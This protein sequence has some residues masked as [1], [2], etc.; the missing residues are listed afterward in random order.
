VKEFGLLARHLSWDCSSCRRWQCKNELLT[1]SI[2]HMDSWANNNTNKTRKKCSSSQQQQQQQQEEEEEEEERRTH[3]S[4]VGGSRCCCVSE[5]KC[6]SFVPFAP[7]APRGSRRE[8]LHRKNHLLRSQ[9]QGCQTFIF[10]TESSS[11]SSYLLTP[12]QAK[13][14]AR[15]GG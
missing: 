5:L 12:K 4:A 11:R 15:N 8:A 3:P 9:C 1:A 6:C 14:Q 7:R 13:I 2:S 10:G